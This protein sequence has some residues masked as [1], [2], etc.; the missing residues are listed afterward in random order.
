[1]KPTDSE[2]QDRNVLAIK[3]AIDLRECLGYLEREGKSK[4]PNIDAI[5]NACDTMRRGIDAH[6]AKYDSRHGTE[7][8][9]V[10][11]ESRLRE[12]GHKQSD[13][14]DE[15]HKGIA[16]EEGHRRLTDKQLAEATPYVEACARVVAELVRLCRAHNVP[17]P[18]A[19]M[20][21]LQ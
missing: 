7:T 15:L 13:Y 20:G 5:R 4:H 16:W 17:I 10:A 2:V 3:I 21:T 12:F 9:W 19:L 18:E 14:I 1:M 11:T 6:L 8:E